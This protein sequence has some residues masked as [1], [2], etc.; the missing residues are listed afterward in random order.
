MHRLGHVWSFS[1]KRKKEFSR[2]SACNLLF[3]AGMAVFHAEPEK[4]VGRSQWTKAIDPSRDDADRVWQWL[5]TRYSQKGIRLD[6]NPN[7]DLALDSLDWLELVLEIEQACNVRLDPAAI[8]RSAT[9]RDFLQSPPRWAGKNWTMD[10]IFSAPDQVL[11]DDRQ[12]WLKPLS[13]AELAA[14]RCLYALNWLLVRSYFPLR[15]EGRHRL[16]EQGPFVIAPHH[17]SYLDS[18][19]LAAAL[20]FRLLRKTYWAAWTGV[21]FGPVFQ[22]L[23][24]LTHVVPIDHQGGAAKNLAYGTAVLRRGYNLVWFPEG[25][26]SRSGELTPLRPGLGILLTRYPVPVVPVVVQGTRD[27]LPPGSRL[28]RSL[29]ITVTIEQPLDPRTLQCQGTGREPHERITNALCDVLAQCCRRAA[30]NLSAGSE[31]C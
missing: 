22:Y 8:A 26:L 7:S 24:R 13:A 11:G 29:P 9:V 21:A 12:F 28:P 16:P 23:R 3:A 6:S 18:F 4:I 30:S 14:G 31:N 1:V 27:A 25:A 20:D 19:V 2:L 5:K 17:V 10:E 15:V